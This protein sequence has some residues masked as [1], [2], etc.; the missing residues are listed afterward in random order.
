MGNGG[1]KKISNRMRKG[2]LT[3]ER[4]V[5]IAVVAAALIAMSVYIRRAI[6]G[7]FRDAAD[8]FGFGRQYEPGVTR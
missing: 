4:A 1:L 5:L 7:R 8:S 3:L 6:S 2:S